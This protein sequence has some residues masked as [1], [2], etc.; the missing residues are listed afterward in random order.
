ML[1]FYTQ[2]LLYLLYHDDS[3]SNINIYIPI[4]KDVRFIFDKPYKIMFV[5]K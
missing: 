3:P 5:E 4:N 2:I 1:L